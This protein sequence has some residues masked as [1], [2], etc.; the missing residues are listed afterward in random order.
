MVSRKHIVLGSVVVLYVASRLMGIV[1]F[2]PHN[3][4]V[5]YA[6]LAMLIDLDWEAYHNFSFDGRMP[7]EFK[8]PLQFWITSLT[9]D[10]W[11]NPLFGTRLWA[12]LF[13]FLGFWFTY[14]LVSRVW[15]IDAALWSAGFITFSEYYLYFDSINLTEPYLYGLGAFYLYCV[16]DTLASR[17]LVSG[18]AAVLCLAALLSMKASGKLWLL[19]PVLMPF[20]VLWQAKR[21]QQINSFRQLLF[22]G[23]TVVL[24][25]S[26][27]WGLHYFLINPEFR[28]LQSGSYQTGLVRSL[29]E[30]QELP[31]SSWWFNLKFFLEK[32]LTFDASEGHL[33]LLVLQVGMTSYWAFRDRSKLK[34][35]LIFWVLFFLSFV[36]LILVTKNPQIRY[37]TGLYFFYMLSGIAMS[38]AWK[39]FKPNWFAEKQLEDAKINVKTEVAE[40]PKSLERNWIPILP[41]VFVFSAMLAWKSFHTYPSLIR[42]GQTPTALQETQGWANGAGIWEMVDHLSQ[43]KPGILLVDHRWGHPGTSA[44]IFYKYYPHLELVDLSQQVHAFVENLIALTHREG[45]QVYIVFDPTR[46][47][48]FPINHIKSSDSLCGQREVITKSYGT[49]RLEGTEIWLCFAQPAAPLSAAEHQDRAY[50]FHQ[51]IAR[52]PD[53]LNNYYYRG[54]HFLALGEYDLA[55][56][57]FTEVIQGV[58]ITPHFFV[59]VRFQNNRVLEPGQRSP[60][61]EEWIHGHLF[62]EVYRLRAQASWGRNDLSAAVDDYLKA[63]THWPDQIGLQKEIDSLCKMQSSQEVTA[64][65]ISARKSLCEDGG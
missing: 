22:M 52:N 20:L 47:L 24:L 15:N 46:G 39:L 19:Y 55:H 33:L 27:G 62:R 31:W 8:E 16:Y 49:K 37:F 1:A 29:A 11:K 9:V 63:Q 3:D 26:I 40:T 2:V 6:R 30:L 38:E 42:Y 23:S 21:P 17:R 65:I 35:Y 64:A 5:I 59:P 32:I 25:S 45:R 53:G 4:E 41:V 13:G 51:A 18:F 43:L 48:D 44:R 54:K 58:P 61:V 12:A 28:S 10:L 56:A 14:R 60:E 50:F 36:P 57:D 34:A 7:G